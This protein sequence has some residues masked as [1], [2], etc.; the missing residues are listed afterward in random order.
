MAIVPS[1]PPADE[2]E[3]HYLS[4]LRQRFKAEVNRLTGGAMRDLLGAHP[5]AEE[6]AF[7]LSYVHAHAW[8]RRDVPAERRAAVV[9][10]FR[11]ADRAFLMDLLVETATAEELLRGIVSGLLAAPET[12]RE[13]RQ[14]ARLLAAHAADPEQ[15]VA[16]ALAAWQGLGILD[17]SYAEAYRDLAR[18]ERER[19]GGM[20]G[21][22][23]RARLAL[24]DALPDPPGPVPPFAKLGVIPAMGCPQTC[25]H[26]MFIW[27]PPMKDA[28]DPGDLYRLVA[29][30]TD[31]VLFTGGDL[32]RHLHHFTRAVRE[33]RPVRTF[34]ILLNGDFADDPPTTEAVLRDLAD[35]VRAR[36]RG[37]PTARV[38]LQVSFDE[39]HQEVV[40]G[41][42]GALRER[43]PVAKIANIV[44]A[45][46]RHPEL[47]LCLVHKQ[48]A[49]NFSMDLFRRGVLARLAAELGRRGQPLQLVAASPSPRLKHNPLDPARP[50]QVVKD[51]SFVL[52]RHPDR[53]ILMTSSTIDAYGRA[54][55]L[56]PGETVQERELLAQVLRDGAPPGE[57]FDTDLM[58]WHNGWATLFA[59][60]HVCLG[61]VRE[62]GEALVL[63]RHRKDPLTDA[64]RRFD[65]R[66]PALYAEVRDDLDTRIAQATGPHHLFHVLTEDPA[67]R[68]HLTRRLI[69]SA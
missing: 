29:R 68:L 6:L 66:L 13:R 4:A 40:A 1:P 57:V 62:D 20:L 51:A 55:L 3:Q 65:R 53:P 63:A 67:V 41:R 54:A 28:P 8:L 38:L 24:V 69:E 18:A 26:C 19:Y 32:T 45:A 7:P 58:F 11:R 52:A 50:G 33:M 49:L 46:P 12:L 35:A 15:V 56:D 16:A 27:R 47:Q 48:T 43:I 60:V 36:P 9:A 23:D 59:A 14:L 30:H 44:E 17:R 64:L 22:A 42:D 10:P 39:F 37:W 2:L 61:N 31:S 5:H 21:D 34:A 25:R